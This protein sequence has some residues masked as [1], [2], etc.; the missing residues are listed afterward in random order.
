M[1]SRAVRKILQEKEK[2]RIA[3][4][5]EQVSDEEPVFELNQNFGFEYFSF[6]FTFFAHFL[7]IN[8]PQF[9]FVL[10]FPPT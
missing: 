9:S 5:V 2:A 10:H 8:L 7:K 1:T 3:E 6:F 4:L